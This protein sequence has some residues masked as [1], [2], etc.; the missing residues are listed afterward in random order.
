MLPWLNQISG[1][2]ARS[3]PTIVLQF[4]YVIIKG[5]K[6]H[7]LPSPSL[8]MVVFDNFE[9]KNGVKIDSRG[10]YGFLNKHFLPW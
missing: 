8:M 1:P 7:V 4:E 6:G 10:H 9:K 2:N 5:S 3:P